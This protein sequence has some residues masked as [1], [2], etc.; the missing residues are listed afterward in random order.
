MKIICVVGSPHGVSGNTFRLTEWTLSAAAQ[1]GAELEIVLLD[2][3]IHPCKGCDSCHRVGQCPQND[4][5]EEVRM[6]IEA[7]DGLLL[8]S[9]NYLGSVSAQ[10]K[11]FMDRCSGAIHRLAFQGRYGAS[12]VTSGGEDNEAVAGY[13][14]RFLLMTGVQPVGAVHATMA[15]MPDGEFT[16]AVRERAHALGERLVSAWQDKFSDPGTE[17]EMKSMRERMRQ[18]IVWKKEEWPYEYG[19]WQEHH[20]LS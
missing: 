9:P 17:A 14:N 3:L 4:S 6:A 20:G 11:A 16:S 8:I 15:L 5:F 12:L 7:A 2:G 13:M 19:Y 1:A 10:M 18:L